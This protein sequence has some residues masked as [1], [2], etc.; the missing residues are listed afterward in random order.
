M[1][2]LNTALD[3]FTFISCTKQDGFPF[4]LWLLG[5]SQQSV[6]QWPKLTLVWLSLISPSL[7]VA[8]AFVYLFYFNF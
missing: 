7:S 6:A 4:S 1:S 8:P 2:V 5:S 3:T